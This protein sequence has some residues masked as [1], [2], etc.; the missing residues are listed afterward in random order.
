MSSPKAQDILLR[1]Y[2][3]FLSHCKLPEEHFGHNI[4]SLSHSVLGLQPGAYPVRT[5]SGRDIENGGQHYEL[6]Q[7]SGYS[8]ETI[9][10]VPILWQIT[11]GTFW[12]QN[13]FSKSFGSLATARNVP[14]PHPVR[15]K[16]ICSRTTRMTL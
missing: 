6:T 15:R 2:I 8:S 14:C 3:L 5:L 16:K 12:S 10:H 13:F 1:Q 7:G 9:S 4:Y 11:K